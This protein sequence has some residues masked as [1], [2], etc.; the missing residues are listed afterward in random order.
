M[1]LECQLAVL[2]PLT[3]SPAHPLLWRLTAFNLVALAGGDVLLSHVLTSNI[4]HHPVL[5]GASGSTTGSFI[6]AGSVKMDIKH[7]YDT[8]VKGAVTQIACNTISSQMTISYN[9]DG[10]GKVVGQPLARCQ[11]CKRQFSL[12]Y[13]T[14]VDGEPIE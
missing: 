8:V 10:S 13:F 1:L 7:A 12:Q 5:T 11:K 6:C 14:D 4:W 9:T 3:R 2:H